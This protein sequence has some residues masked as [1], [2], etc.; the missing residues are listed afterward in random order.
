MHFEERSS[1][2]R[3]VEEAT[4]GTKPELDGKELM[5]RVVKAMGHMTLVSS[6]SE[7]YQLDQNPFQNVNRFL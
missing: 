2:I 1:A 6:W 5:V 3:A 4:E 7:A